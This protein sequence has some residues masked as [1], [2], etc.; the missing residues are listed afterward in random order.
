MND[1]TDKVADVVNGGK[2]RASDS[3]DQA[4]KNLA[5]DRSNPDE[6]T[7]PAK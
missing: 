7:K 2:D 1:F 5:S 4:R 6:Q 3:A